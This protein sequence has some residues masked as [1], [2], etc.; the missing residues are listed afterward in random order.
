MP[1]QLSHLSERSVGSRVSVSML[2]DGRG[3]C[4]SHSS[5]FG[6]CSVG[7]VVDIVPPESAIILISLSWLFVDG[8]ARK[9][10]GRL[11]D[12]D[13]ERIRS[14]AQSSHDYLVE[15]AKFESQS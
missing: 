12:V 15:T 11:V 1:E 4:F 3:P 2:S 6:G 13:V 5:S 14:L 7:G 10:N 9:R 8:E